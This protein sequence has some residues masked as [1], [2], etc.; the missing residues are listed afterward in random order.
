ML[1]ESSYHA[2]PTVLSQPPSPLS[3]T[4]ALRKWC[5]NPLRTFMPGRDQ[6]YLL[7]ATVSTS[8]KWE[9]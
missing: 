9:C 3:L 6:P 1:D 8:V 7:L 2:A 4:M 5:Q